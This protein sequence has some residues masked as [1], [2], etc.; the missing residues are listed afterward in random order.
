MMV[1]RSDYLTAR[2]LGEKVLVLTMV[3]MVMM[4]SA[5]DVHCFVEFSWV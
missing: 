4:I 2:L 1:W 5:L 3:M